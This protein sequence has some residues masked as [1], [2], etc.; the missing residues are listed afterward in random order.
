MKKTE[1]IHV[2]I[3]DPMGA[4]IT[5]VER[6]DSASH[7]PVSDAFHAWRE[8]NKGRFPRG[9]EIMLVGEGAW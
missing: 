3:I 5:A 6:I 7:T 1:L 2:K 9:C 8:R 4:K